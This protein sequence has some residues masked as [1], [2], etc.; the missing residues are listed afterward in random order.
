MNKKQELGPLQ[1]EWINRLRSGKYIQG[2]TFLRCR[3]P[4]LKAD[5]FCCL[6]IACELAI[7]AGC[8]IQAERRNNAVYYDGLFTASLPSQ[9]VKMM[10]FRGDYGQAVGY[11]GPQLSTMNDQGRSFEEIADVVS[12]NPAAYFWEPA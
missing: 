3:D 12:R 11:R 5:K 1:T 6:G 7:E 2:E 9:V 4:D 10:K 8:E